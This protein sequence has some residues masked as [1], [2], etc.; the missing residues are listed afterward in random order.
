MFTI[1]RKRIPDVAYPLACGVTGGQIVN[2]VVQ[3]PAVV[4]SLGRAIVQRDDAK[5]GFI[6]AFARSGF[7]VDDKGRPVFQTTTCTGA[8]AGVLGITRKEIQRK[9]SAIG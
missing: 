3:W 2:I 7:T 5:Q 9:A 4:R 6:Y 8:G 1:W